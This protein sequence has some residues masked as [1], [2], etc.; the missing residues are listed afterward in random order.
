M[1]TAVPKEFEDLVAAGKRDPLKTYEATYAGAQPTDI[2]SIAQAK[3]FLSG[4][5]ND[6]AMKYANRPLDGVRI[7]AIEAFPGGAFRAGRFFD[8]EEM[9]KEGF[10]ADKKCRLAYHFNKGHALAEQPEDL[11]LNPNTTDRA[12]QFEVRDLVFMYF[13]LGPEV[14]WR[15]IEK[16]AF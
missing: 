15:Q 1:N 14:A 13:N 16:A 7:L 5:L 9:L 4:P 12:Q 2:A 6:L 3:L 11:T 8:A 10:P